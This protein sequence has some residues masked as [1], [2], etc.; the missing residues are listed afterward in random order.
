[1]VYN[2]ISQKWEPKTVQQE[3]L[4]VIQGWC[5]SQTVILTNVA[6]FIPMFSP[7]TGYII[8]NVGDVFEVLSSTQLRVNRSGSYIFNMAFH[9]TNN[10]SNFRIYKNGSIII[11]GPGAGA[12]NCNMISNI[13]TLAANDIIQVNNDASI[14]DNF[15]NAS[16]YI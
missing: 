1:M 4:N 9:P 10:G 6:G 7:T 13:I 12:N 16:W 5:T 14:N 11:Y 3:V 8:S 15:Q 2:N